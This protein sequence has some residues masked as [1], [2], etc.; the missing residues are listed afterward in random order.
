MIT[1]PD[2]TNYFTSGEALTFT[3]T[4]IVENTLIQGAGSI[5]HPLTRLRMS[6]PSGDLREMY[7]SYFDPAGPN[8]IP[9]P[10]Q[11]TIVPAP[12]AAL[13]GGIGAGVVGWFRRKQTL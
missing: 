11:I 3:L 12:G 8:P 6:Q 10:C 1:S 5:N 7:W 13:L 9:L 4:D 2:L